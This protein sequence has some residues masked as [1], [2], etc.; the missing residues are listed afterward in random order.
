[1]IE[2]SLGAL[3]TFYRAGVRYMGLTHFSNTDWADSGTDDR[4]P[5]RTTNSWISPGG[6]ISIEAGGMSCA[7]RA[8][9][10]GSAKAKQAITTDNSRM[11][12]P[13]GWGL[14]AS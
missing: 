1:M 11:N 9:E 14:I 4:D 13:W 5:S 6:G 7:S 12:R 8:E 10:S 2:N 3:R